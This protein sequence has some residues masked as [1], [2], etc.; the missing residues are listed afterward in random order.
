M[1]E[2]SLIKSQCQANVPISGEGYLLI[3]C[4]IKSGDLIAQFGRATD[5]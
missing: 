5:F 4:F 3:I 1:K 2:F